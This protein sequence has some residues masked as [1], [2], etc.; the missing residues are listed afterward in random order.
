MA[1]MIKVYALLCDIREPL[2]CERRP[3]ECARKE[4]IIEEWRVLLPDL[5][6]L[7]D[8]LLLH[9]LLCILRHVVV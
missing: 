3:F 2:S 9:G 6:L 4:H 8:D 5:V 1:K 7:I